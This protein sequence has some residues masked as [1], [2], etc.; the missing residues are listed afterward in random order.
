MWSGTA[1]D[2]VI[3]GVLYGLGVGTFQL[4]GGFRA[5]SDALRRW[6]NA[7]SVRRARELGWYPPAERGRRP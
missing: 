5:A 7:T 1:W 6:G 3:V 4:L 2:W